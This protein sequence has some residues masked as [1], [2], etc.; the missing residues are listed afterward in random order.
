MV[1]IGGSSKSSSL[2]SSSSSGSSHSSKSTEM[3]VL[4]YL[5]GCQGST[6]VFNSTIE[7]NQIFKRAYG[8]GSD[9]SDDLMANV[10][11]IL[12]VSKTNSI[13]TNPLSQ[14][15]VFM[16]CYT[17]VLDPIVRQ[18]LEKSI[19]NFLP[20]Y[21]KAIIKNMTGDIPIPNIT[22]NHTK[23]VEIMQSSTMKD[24]EI[25]SCMKA[26]NT[27][28]PGIQSQSANT[29]PTNAIVSIPPNMHKCIDLV[30]TT[31]SLGIG[32]NAAV[33][34]NG[35]VSKTLDNFVVL[36]LTGLD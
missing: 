8:S 14:H 11:Q 4:G 6:G 7:D 13:T 29:Q 33:G 22:G 27:V 34:Q 19:P 25:I 2:S 15:K 9:C 32:L 30:A 18:A 20:K 12:N 36:A 1:H 28:I 16:Q 3:N 23:D 31:Y 10:M 21:E 24:N 5:E 35:N 17:S 26:H